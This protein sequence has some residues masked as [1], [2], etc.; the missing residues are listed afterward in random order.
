MD[1]NR[2]VW[3]SRQVRQQKSHRSR[4][5]KWSSWS[6]PSSCATLRVLYLYR[7]I[8]SESADSVNHVLS[9]PISVY[10]VAEFQL[11]AGTGHQRTHP[12][13]LLA[14]CCKTRHCSLVPFS[15]SVFCIFFAGS[16]CCSPLFSC[17]VSWLMLF[18]CQ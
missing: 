14:G 3:M 15:L 13:R 16:P 18:G 17:S 8:V 5:I 1:D 2:Q 6:R 7:V 9:T 10:S 11:L 4:A 12:L